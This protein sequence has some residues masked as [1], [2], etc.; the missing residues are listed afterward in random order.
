MKAIHLYSVAGKLQD[1]A[2][3]EQSESIAAGNDDVAKIWQWVKIV[4]GFC[5]DGLHDH[6]GDD[7]VEALSNMEKRDSCGCPAGTH[8][9][10]Q[11][12][13]DAIEDADDEEVH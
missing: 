8:E 13:F 3:A 2:A 1:F 10:A 11:R 4:A 9:E 12:C 7:L 6:A 5:L